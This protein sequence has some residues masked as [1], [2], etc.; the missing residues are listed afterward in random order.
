MRTSRSSSP[1]PTP[2]TLVIKPRRMVG[3]KGSQLDSEDLASTTN[4]TETTIMKT[5]KKHESKFFDDQR[6]EEVI[7]RAPVAA[8]AILKVFL[9]V[10]FIRILLIFDFVSLSTLV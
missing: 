10:Y 6:L 5:L 2:A 4:L 3:P 1:N 7:G 9:S 8:H